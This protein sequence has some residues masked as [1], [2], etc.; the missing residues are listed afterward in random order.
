MRLPSLDDLPAET[1]RALVRVDFN[2]PLAAGEVADTFRVEAELPTI[3]ALLGRGLAVVLISHLGRPKG[4]DPAKSLR[5]VARTLERLLG[6][7]VVFLPGGPLDAGVRSRIE[8]A[9]PGEVL[10]LENLRFHPG[11][12]AN[13]P[14]FARALAGL[15]DAF[16]QDAFGAVHR[17][18]A[19]IAGVPR[20]LPSVAG[21][22]VTSEVEAL[23]GLL[24][25]PSH[26]FLVIIGGAKTSDKLALL[27]RLAPKADALL[28]GGA[29]A[30]TFFLAEGR[31][32][33][34][35]LV[36]HDQVEAARGLLAAYPGRI[37]LPATV[38]VRN[39]EGTVRETSPG[40]VAPDEAVLDIGREAV[41]TWKDAVFGA[42]RLFWNGPMGRFEEPPFDRGTLA[43]AALVAETPGVT[44]VG[45]GD[46]LAAV[47][48]SGLAR[49]MTHLSTGGGASLAYLEG[50][51]LPGLQALLGG[52]ARP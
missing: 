44:V 27:G 13:A 24:E 28:L 50:R 6:E 47:R 19:S 39:G 18:H 20:L 16:V 26:P 42:A 34:V 22:L 38:M 14:A 23:D 48:R 11:E 15:G 41:E 3:H 40:D 29:L 5:P 9:R 10:L 51:E 35:S 8:A 4:P 1:R 46:S 49:R 52:R 12:K 7:R 43:L 17:A 25:A 45:G 37:R 30:N 2:V 32:V 36:E 33:G 31:G 21:P